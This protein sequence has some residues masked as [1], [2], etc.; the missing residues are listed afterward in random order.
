MCRGVLLTIRSEQRYEGQDTDVIEL[1][2]EG[3]LE[4]LGE[5]NWRIVYEESEITGLRGVTTTF[6]IQPGRVV[7]TRTGELESE[8][9]FEENVRHESLYRLDFG[10]LM[11]VVCAKRIEV[12]LTGEGG[13]LEI[14]YGIQIEQTQAGVVTYHIDVKPIA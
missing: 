11:L 3:V 7:L 1:V 5:N 9:I 8:M 4:N 10:A 13:T 2:T 6:D 12:E 14:S